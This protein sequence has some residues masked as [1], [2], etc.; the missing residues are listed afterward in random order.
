MIKVFIAAR[1][2]A[3]RLEGVRAGLIALLAWTWLGTAPAPALAQQAPAK[4]AET[5]PQEPGKPAEGDAAAEDDE[6]QPVV[7]P[8]ASHKASSLEIYK[9]PNAEPL[10]DPKK[11]PEIRAQRIPS[12]QEIDQV[13]LMAANPVATVDVNAITNVVNGMIAQMTNTRNIQAVVD[14]ASEQNANVTRAIQVATQNLLEPIFTSRNAKN[15]Q[16]QNQFNKV[17]LQKLPPV[18][19]HHLVPRIQAMIVLAQSANPDALKV[20][21]DEIKSPNQ[22]VWVKLWAFRGITNIKLLANRLSA[23]QESEAAK[24]ISDQLAKNKDWPWWVQHRALEALTALRQGFLPTSPRTADMAAVAFQYLTDEALRPEVRA[25][26][27]LAL[28]S[29]QVTSAVP[30]YNVEIAAYATAQLAAT[31]VERIVDGFSEN[32]TRS[33]QLTTLLVGPVLQAFEGQAGVRDSGFLNSPVLANKAEVQKYVDA[34]KP[35]AKACAALIGAP[36]GQIEALTADLK[37]KVA[38]FKAFLAKATPA[39]ASLFPGG[40]SYAAPAAEAAPPQAAAAPSAEA[41]GNRR[42]P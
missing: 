16:F 31:L 3:P 13:K 4:P 14:P 21:L 20:L 6:T 32:R 19:K 38:E 18:F 5:N 25:E 9:D 24:T 35:S 7:D 26:A 27:A 12:P 39:E 30:K 36:S 17:L 33:Q 22:T 8:S 10:L 42:E 29:M 37:T 23:S 1:R 28:G 34:M 41:G 40:P 11:F 15:V 2:V